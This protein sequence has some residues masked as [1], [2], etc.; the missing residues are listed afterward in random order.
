MVGMKTPLTAIIFD[1]GNV[2]VH[3]DPRALY[4]RFFPDPEAVDSF[5]E[6][7]HFAEWN[8]LQDA[9]RSY[10]EGVAE[11]SRNFPQY[12]DL[13]Q[14][15]DTY[16]IESMTEVQT[17]TIEIA[18]NLKNSGWPL[19]LLSNFSAEKFELMEAS[20]PTL[21]SFLGLFDDKIISGEHGVIKPS[22][23][24]F[25]ITLDRIQRQASEC[26]FIDDSLANVQA[27]RALDF[28]AIQY[29]SPAQLRRDLDRFSIKD[30]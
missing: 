8:M 20:R 11:L 3:W 2:F 12:A 22:R 4:N 10:K 28:S 6:E 23:R 15:Y 14:A 18:T 26:L 9:G 30:Y 7:I 24:I 25:E 1:F 13:I 29:H 27:A 19:Y 17:E 5:L 21:R 16:W